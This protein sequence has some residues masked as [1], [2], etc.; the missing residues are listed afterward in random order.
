MVFYYQFCHHAYTNE[1]VE[2]CY[3]QCNYKL[4]N[5]STVSC[6]LKCLPDDFADKDYLRVHKIQAEAQQGYI[7][8]INECPE[9][10]NFTCI[11]SCMSIYYKLIRPYA[12]EEPRDIYQFCYHATSVKPVNDCSKPCDYSASKNDNVS[13]VDCVLKCI[14][15]GFA[16]RDY[17]TV[18][19]I[20][21]VTDVA[22]AQKVYMDC[23]ARSLCTDNE[24]IIEC[25][26]RQGYS[27]KVHYEPAG[28]EAPDEEDDL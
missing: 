9:C 10:T 11:S 1:P 25:M 8:C 5:A 26:G 24:A 18:H 27:A 12:Y 15:D 7:H 22:E 2:K 23:I 28:Y 20:E 16:D 19:K 6:V 3:K 21:S 13:A 17:L 4:N 14:P